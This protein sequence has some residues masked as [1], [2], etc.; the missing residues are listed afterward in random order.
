MLRCIK[1]IAF[2]LVASVALP[3]AANADINIG[4]TLSATGPAASL[5]IPE[6]N[7]IE[8]L[9]T[10][11]AGQKINWIVLDDAS[12]TTKAVTNIRKL[13]AE[14]KVDVVIGSTITPNSLA[15]IDVAADGETPMISCAASARIVDPTNPKTKWVFKTLKKSY[16]S[17]AKRS[18]DVLDNKA[19]ACVEH[20]MLFVSLSPDALGTEERRDLRA[21]LAFASRRQPLGEPIDWQRTAWPTRWRLLN[22]EQRFEWIGEDGSAQE[23]P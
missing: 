17:G 12:D 11:V 9:P 6:R 5:G 22:H 23:R 1:A 8:L 13:I 2:G 3:N 16:S 21:A 14:D 19:G 15:M 20:T 4:V 18:L 10:T 7:T